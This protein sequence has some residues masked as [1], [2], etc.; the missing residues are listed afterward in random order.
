MARE[1]IQSSGAPFKL[2]WPAIFGGLFAATGV[3]LLL[4]ALG[5]ALGL[6]RLDPQQPNLARMAGIGTSVWVIVSSFLAMFVG[7][8]VTARSA[9]YLGRGNGALHGI[10]LW[11][12]TAFIVAVSLAS[13]LGSVASQ[14]AQTGSEIASSALNQT[15]I[16][17]REVLGPV[18]ERL[19]R[20]GKPALTAPQLR[21]AAQDALMMSVNQGRLDRQVFITALADNT[22][23]SENDVQQM[24]AGATQRLDQRLTALR[25]QANQAAERLAQ[26]T[27][28]MFWGL[29]FLLVT[30]LLGSVLGASTGVTRRQRELV[31][32]ATPVVP[33]TTRS[34]PVY[35]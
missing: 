1:H 23:L 5:L 34:E 32:A 16:D 17:T 30:S 22:Q 19:A 2:S 12:S 24:F 18:N 10:V 11:G 15:G 4:Y 29:F 20:E 33:M 28:R 21:A 31:V 25:S 8:L 35:P 27:G 6:S 14:F 13:V 7:G 26:A 9:G 3:W